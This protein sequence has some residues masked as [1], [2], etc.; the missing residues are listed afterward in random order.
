MFAITTWLVWYVADRTWDYLIIALVTV[1]F[2]PLL[3]VTATGDVS[4]YL[5]ATVF[6]GGISGKDQIVIVSAL[7]T[8]LFAIMFAAG[9]VY[10]V[11]VL[12]RIEQATQNRQSNTPRTPGRGT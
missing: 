9:S 5:P 10:L 12:W 4:R 8:L 7:S 6:S 3:V 1:P 11:K 2:F